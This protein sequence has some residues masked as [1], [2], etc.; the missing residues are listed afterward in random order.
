MA[1]AVAKVSA[2]GNENST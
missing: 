1:L 2:D